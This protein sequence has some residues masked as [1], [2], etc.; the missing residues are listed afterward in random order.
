[1]HK[2]YLKVIAILQIVAI[3]AVINK[4]V[5]GS[6]YSYILILSPIWIPILVDIIGSIAVHLLRKIKY[7]NFGE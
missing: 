5:S 4:F 6:E 1:M 3:L 7:R 2:K